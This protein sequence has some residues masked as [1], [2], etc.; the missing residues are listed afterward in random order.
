M[1]RKIL[2]KSIICIVGLSLA[3]EL[4]SFNVVTNDKILIAFFGGGFLGAGIGLA[5][6]NGTVLD[7]AELLGVF[8]NNKYGVSISKIFLFFNLF[9]FLVATVYI[10]IETV[11][12]SILTY[13]VTSKVIDV[14]IAGFEDFIGITI[15]SV[16]SH[17]IEASIH[18]NLGV[19]MTIYD[20]S[21]GYG[22]KGINYENRVIQTVINRI[23]IRKLEQIVLSEDADAFIMEYD[24][25]TVRGG[26]LRRFLR[27]NP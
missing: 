7:G 23:D 17:E 8:L 9:L 22:K 26:I 24:V 16:K 6:R 1:S 13:F 3:L 15:I 21:T 2:L 14:F 4:E 19:G 12:F 18:R 25:N 11:L 27:L 10:P 5:I 20:N